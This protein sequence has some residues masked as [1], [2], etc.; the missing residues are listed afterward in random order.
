MNKLVLRIFA[1]IACLFVAYGGLRVY[2][3]Y[4]RMPLVESLKCAGSNQFDAGMCEWRLKNSIGQDDI[5]FLNSMAGAQYLLLM[6]NKDKQKELLDF[7]ISRG[8]KINATTTALTKGTT[9]LHFAAGWGNPYVVQ[10][11]LEHG[12]SP[13]PIDGAGKTPIDYAQAKL[14]GKFNQPGSDHAAVIAQINDA[15]S[16][17]S[18][19]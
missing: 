8:L 17:Q 5:E 13:N 9:A 12:A 7:L 4:W 10:L 6:D 19:R 3:T 16:K 11:L 1:V 2:G 14:H 15:M 18:H